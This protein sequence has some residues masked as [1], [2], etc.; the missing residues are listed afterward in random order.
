MLVCVQFLVTYVDYDWNRLRNEEIN[1]LPI[2]IMFIYPL[3][4]YESLGL[5]NSL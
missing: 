5:T 4:F 3:S 2:R 1:R